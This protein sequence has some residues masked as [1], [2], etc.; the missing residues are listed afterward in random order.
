MSYKEIKGRTQ[1]NDSRRLPIACGDGVVYLLTKAGPH[2]VLLLPCCFR[3]IKLQGFVRQGGKLHIKS[4]KIERN[5]TVFIVSQ[6]SVIVTDT[7]RPK[8]EL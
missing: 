3:L 1:I 4:L 7:Y 6:E 2:I 8:S 5:M